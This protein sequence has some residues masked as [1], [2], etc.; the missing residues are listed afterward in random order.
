MINCVMFEGPD[1]CGKTTLARYYSWRTGHKHLVMDRSVHSHLVYPL[2]KPIS[3]RGMTT[4]AY[5][6]G[7]VES[8]TGLVRS[9]NHIVVVLCVVDY[10]T[11][12][13][14]LLAERPNEITGSFTPELFQQTLNRYVEA[15]RVLPFKTTILVNTSMLE[16]CVDAINLAMEWTNV[17]QISLNSA[18]DWWRRLGRESHDIKF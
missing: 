4:D 16:V 8:G 13:N 12:L 11:A 5:H 2:T 7:V 9:F 18:V 17:E 10:F 3:P 15:A 1:R 6:L 14:R